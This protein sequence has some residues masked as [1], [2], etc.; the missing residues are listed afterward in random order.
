MGCKEGPKLCQRGG[1]DPRPRVEGGVRVGLPA[2]LIRVEHTDVVVAREVQ[3]ECELAD[4]RPDGALQSEH[5]QSPEELE[6]SDDELEESDDENPELDESNPTVLA[7][8]PCAIST[9]AGSGL[10]G[11][12]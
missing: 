11:S 12:L 6:E 5:A 7:S 10:P 4:Q 1:I 3:S 2:L 9:A 8:N